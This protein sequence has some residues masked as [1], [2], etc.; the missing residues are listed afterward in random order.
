MKYKIRFWLSQKTK[1]W[2]NKVNIFKI[3]KMQCVIFI[4][5]KEGMKV[6]KIR[7]M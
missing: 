4:R 3:K 1:G 2:I 5:S 7:T 6:K